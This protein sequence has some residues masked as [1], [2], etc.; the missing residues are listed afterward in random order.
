MQDESCV[1][2]WSRHDSSPAAQATEKRGKPDVQAF[3]LGGDPKSCFPQHKKETVE[4]NL[5]AKGFPG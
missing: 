2:E 1:R 5:C 4:K 3:T